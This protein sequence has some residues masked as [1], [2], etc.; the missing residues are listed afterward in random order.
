MVNNM[1]FK[2]IHKRIKILLLIVLFCFFVI[3]FRVF[4]IQVID[5]KKLNKLANSLWSR[6]LPIEAS[7]GS[8]LTNDY[9]IVTIQ[10]NV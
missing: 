2:N 5:Y 4:Y 9:K 10:N 3:V 7:R 8:I 6:N 1:F